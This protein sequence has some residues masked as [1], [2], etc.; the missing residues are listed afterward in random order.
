[1]CL[2]SRAKSKNGGRML[3]EKLD[4]IGMTLP[5]GRRKAA[6]VTLLTSLVE[7]TLPTLI[8]FRKNEKNFIHAFRNSAFSPFGWFLNR[9]L[10]YFFFLGCGVREIDW[11]SETAIINRFFPVPRLKLVPGTSLPRLCRHGCERSMQFPSRTEIFVKSRRSRQT[12]MWENFE[13]AERRRS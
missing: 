10:T 13:T 9:F 6:N 7:G 5:A 8:F 3:R 4:K 11:G 12:I 1:M 2:F